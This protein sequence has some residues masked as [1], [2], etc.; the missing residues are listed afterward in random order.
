MLAATLPY[1]LG[2]APESFCSRLAKN[3]GRLDGLLQGFRE[4]HSGASSLAPP[5]LS[6]PLRTWAAYPIR[7]WLITPSKSRMTR[8][9]SIASNSDQA[10][11]AAP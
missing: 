9:M 4:L 8:P 10:N 3:C 6:K 2:E 7:R 1:G 5:G 11:S